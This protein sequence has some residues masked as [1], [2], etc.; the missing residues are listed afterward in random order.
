MLNFAAI[1]IECYY[2]VNWVTDVFEHILFRRSILAC[3]YIGT[4]RFY[5]IQLMLSWPYCLIVTGYRPPVFHFS[6][7]VLSNL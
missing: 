4:R 2:Y 3:F 5:E 7:F 6:A 1:I